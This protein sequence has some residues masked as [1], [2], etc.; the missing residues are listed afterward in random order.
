MDIKNK[1]GDTSPI[2]R[3]CGKTPN[4]IFPE[5]QENLTPIFTR[6]LCLINSP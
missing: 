2:E 3:T 6:V 1:D 4:G 5:S